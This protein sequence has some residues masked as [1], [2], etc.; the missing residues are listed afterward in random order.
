MKGRK[1]QGRKELEKYLNNEVLTARQTVLAKCYD[2]CCGYIDGKL[3]CRIKTCP[4][5]YFM[6][7]RKNKP[8]KPKKK[9]TPK[10]IENDLRF[11]RKSSD[12]NKTMGCRK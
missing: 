9:R 5:Y 11:G 2:C 4:C 10:Q 1:A 8:E 6:P 12:T 7:Y 3:D